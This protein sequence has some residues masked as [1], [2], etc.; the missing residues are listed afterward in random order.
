M[1][2]TEARWYCVDSIGLATLCRDEAD[3]KHV[4][5]E[6]SIAWPATMPCRA[7]QL[8]DVGALVAERD[9]LRAEVE[10][11]RRFKSINA[12]RL[13]ALQ[14]LK[15]HAEQEA[16]KGA[17]AIATVASERA[18][19]AILT[20]EVERLRADVA[21]LVELVAETVNEWDSRIVDGDDYAACKRVVE[22]TMA[23]L[24][25]LLA[26]HHPPQALADC[27]EEFPHRAPYRVAHLAPVLPLNAKVTGQGGAND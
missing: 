12:P 6:R 5:E 9:S 24:R 26:K 11:L 21:E 8:G 2:D 23:P 10:G 13:E 25:A 15:D 3:A 22:N 19:N 14:G 20:D 7:V 16:A 1:T 4:A 18:A 27:T 17:E